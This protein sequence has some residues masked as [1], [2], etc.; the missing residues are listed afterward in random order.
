MEILERPYGTR[1]GFASLANIGFCLLEVNLDGEVYKYGISSTSECCKAERVGNKWKL[2]KFDVSGNLIERVMRTDVLI[3][4]AWYNVDEPLWENSTYADTIRRCKEFFSIP[5]LDKVKT[6]YKTSNGFY[7]YVT[8]FGD[9]WNTETMVKLGIHINSSGY[10]QL[11]LGSV[12]NVR[13][14]RL[15][16]R[17]FVTIP[18]DLLAK[19][20][21]EESLVVNHLDGNKLNNRWDNLEWTTN[22]DNMAHASATGL[23]HT[24]ID[25]Q[26]LERVWQYLQAGYS[27][28][29]ISKET[30]IHA[31]TVSSIR[32]GT[33]P[34]YRTDKYTWPT[35]SFDVREK[36]HRD[37]LAM[38][39]VQMFNEGMSYQTI[40]NKLGF[41]SK[42]PVITLIGTCRDLITRKLRTKLD[43][44]TIFSIYDEF[45]YTDKNNCEIGR[46]YNV[47]KQYISDLRIGRYCSK[48]ACEYINSKGLDGYWQGYRHPKQ[49]QTKNN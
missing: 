4:C 47:S 14:H 9:V 39:C 7:Y 11:A 19:G 34:R 24:T 33:S 20:F 3:G 21:T 1:E 13:V 6:I 48:L 36:E 22:D 49:N 37:E 43:K 29:N 44:T 5:N 45:T 26:L 17:H 42:W 30:G 35:H 15:V 40:A 10:Y 32:Q 28:I 18:E 16:A 31:R 41:N 25:K 46:Q 12:H 2:H 27:D 23:M 38:K 8:R